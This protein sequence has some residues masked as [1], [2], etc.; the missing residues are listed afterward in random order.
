M[1]KIRNI[2][3]LVTIV[4][5]VIA[6]DYQYYDDFPPTNGPVGEYVYDSYSQYFNSY[7]KL[8]KEV[9]SYG[10][11]NYVD[12]YNDVSL[13]ITPNFGWSYNINLSNFVVHKVGNGD[14][15]TS[16]SISSQEIWVNG[17]NFNVRGINS[18]PVKD[19]LGNVIALYDGYIK[20][21]SIVF[22]YESTDIQEKEKA[23]TKI[24]SIRKN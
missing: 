12:Y 19:S 17:K 4:T 13:K 5:F 18:N 2:L 8:E 11:L 6:C 22:E 1:M 20:G 15:V 3:M 24:K 10:Y 7:E 14:T 16:F 9:E 21:D 23:K